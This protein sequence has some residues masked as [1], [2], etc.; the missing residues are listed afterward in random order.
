MQIEGKTTKCRN[1]FNKQ[2]DNDPIKCVPRFKEENT[3]DIWEKGNK[4]LNM[5]S[6]TNV[7]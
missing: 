6:K 2:L 4:D 1:Q 7:Y 3:V 5:I